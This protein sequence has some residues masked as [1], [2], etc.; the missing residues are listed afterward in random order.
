MQDPNHGF[1]PDSPTLAG[2]A[3]GEHHS[4]TA[5]KS[6]SGDS[7]SASSQ[8]IATIADAGPIR[9]IPSGK[10]QSAVPSSSAMFAPGTLVGARYQIQKILGQGGMGA[11]YQ[12]R[13]QELDR[14]IALKIIRP[15][16]AS[17]AGILQRF[18]QELILSRNVTHKNVVHIFDLGEAEGT[19]FITMEFVE[20]E[21]LRSV[22]RHHGKFSARKAVAIVQQVCRALEAAHAEG[23]IHRDLKPQNIMRDP[24]GRIVVMDFGLARSLESDGMTQT[25]ALVGT[26]EYMSP[27]QALGEP[28]DQRSDLFAVGLIFYEL[29]TAKS[30]YRADTGIATLVKRTREA[31]VPV[32]EIDH[33][34]PKSL[35]M[36]VSRCL[37]RVPKDRYNSAQELLSQLETW[38]SNPSV[39]EKQM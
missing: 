30:P 32:S 29:L 33:S 20:G 3:E 38:Q 27:E 35:S 17:N 8:D 12:A 16:L 24:Q 19:K 23:V 39:V 2:A 37:E 4:G 9:D 11:V 31:A 14:T 36:V 15:E 6:S 34:V 5:V 21:D 1:D 7:S 22:L 18:K 28:L 25:G 26:L 10:I 13:D